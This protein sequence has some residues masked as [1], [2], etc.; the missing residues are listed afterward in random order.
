GRAPRWRSLRFSTDPELTSFVPGRWHHG[1]GYPPELPPRT[2]P[3]RAP[4]SPPPTHRD[5]P[6]ISLAQRLRRTDTNILPAPRA[7]IPAHDPFAAHAGGSGERA[8]RG[9]SPGHRGRAGSAHRSRASR[10][11]WSRPGLA[12]R[13]R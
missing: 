2:G 6:P 12:E 8:V 1:G 4:R 5:G 13:L 3:A 10:T 9:V 7:Q 11:S